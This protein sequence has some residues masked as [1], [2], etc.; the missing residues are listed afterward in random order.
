[1]D[2]P[3]KAFTLNGSTEYEK[4][5]IMIEEIYG[6]PNETCYD[7]GYDFRGSVN[8]H[9]GGFAVNNAPIFSSTG[10]LFRLL[11]SLQEC[12][13]SL[14]GR[15]IF[16]HSLENNLS[17]DLKM[18]KMGRAVVEGEY[19]EF[20]HINTRLIFEMQTDQT[21]VLSAIKDLQYIESVFG[22]ELGKRDE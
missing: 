9:V 4:I 1:M 13:K 10:A 17:F 19:Q 6:F 11:I 3:I 8:I 5:E 16:S 18:G 2:L 15:A 7:G 20:S 14:E 12:Y 22:D 21:C